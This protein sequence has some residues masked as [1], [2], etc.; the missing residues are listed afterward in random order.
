MR[1]PQKSGKG[2]GPHA[3]SSLMIYALMWLSLAM[4][5]AALDAPLPLSLSEFPLLPLVHGKHHYQE[6]GVASLPGL[7]G[8]TRNYYGH[9]DT[10]MADD[11]ATYGNY[12]H[13]LL[14]TNTHQHH[15]PHP[16][17]SSLGTTA[18]GFAP[19]YYN[20]KLHSHSHSHSQFNEDEEPRR[21]PSANIDFVINTANYEP[22]SAGYEEESHHR[23][24]HHYQSYAYR[25]R[26]AFPTSPPSHYHFEQISNYRENR[27]NRQQ[28]EEQHDDSS[29]VY[30]RLKEL[31][32][33]AN[34]VKRQQEASLSSH[35]QN[36]ELSG[37]HHGQ[38][39]QPH[40]QHQ[41]Y[42]QQHQ[43]YQQ[44]HQQYQQQHQ[45]EK[46]PHLH[47]SLPDHRQHQR[48][49]VA[50]DQQLLYSHRDGQ[51]ADLPAITT[52][53][54]HSPESSKAIAG[55]PLAK[56]IEITKNVPIT[57]Y[58]KQHV[59]Y[60]QTVHVQVPRT[61]IATIPKPM[62]IKIPVA[63]TV[64]VPQMQEVTIPIERVKPV[65][66]ERPIPFVVERRVPYRVEKPVVQ[67]V[68]YPYPVK[69][70]V[71]RTVVHKQR[72]HYVAPGWS[73]TGNQLLG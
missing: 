13:K 72:P 11:L 69:V 51:V 19:F 45:N 8:Y 1:R 48:V 29:S 64:A 27:E 56:H 47:Q 31:Q 57:H 21:D 68:Y 49:G 3:N 59:P 52:S 73:A 14:A 4:T 26:V 53:V 15:R 12:A 50:Q 20:S 10:A 61:V 62:P 24:P 63:N 42:Q 22:N 38:H 9:T 55:L 6:A 54:R 35:H 43:Q 67:P 34:P 66:V 44:Q 37:R 33:L 32:T 41:Q 39:Q 17:A 7:T 2:N 5:M 40:Q 60:K 70:P 30:A 28:Q 36:Q 58:Q 46:Q 71:V 65:P 16:V 18:N 25:P 23:E